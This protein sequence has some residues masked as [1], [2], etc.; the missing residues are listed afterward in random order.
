MHASEEFWS[1]I[2]KPI[3]SFPTQRYSKLSRY[4]NYSFLFTETMSVG[5]LNIND[6]FSSSSLLSIEQNWLGKRFH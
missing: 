2:S 5:S 3:M 6:G 1:K 4:L